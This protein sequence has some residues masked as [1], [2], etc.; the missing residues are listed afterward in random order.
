MKIELSFLQMAGFFSAGVGLVLFTL[1]TR[2]I[3]L[4][5]IG[6]GAIVLGTI[7]D[8]LREIKKNGCQT[9]GGL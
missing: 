5:A 6:V 2:W 1:T 3:G 9:K 8:S 7:F 4:T